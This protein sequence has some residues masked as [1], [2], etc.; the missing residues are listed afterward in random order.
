MVTTQS[1]NGRENQSFSR[2]GLS[3]VIEERYQEIFQ[4]IKQRMGNINLAQAIPAGIVLTGGASRI[5]GIS[6]LAEAI[7]QAPVRVGKPQGLIGLSDILSNP[8]YST[9]VG[10]ILF[11]QK[12]QEE[13]Y[14]DFAML[15]EKG[16]LNKAFRWIQNTF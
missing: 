12:E 9:A 16:L 14:M 6:Q 13:D 4:I 15:N 1:I 5:E 11:A 8:I 3:T 7:F 10:L 2:H